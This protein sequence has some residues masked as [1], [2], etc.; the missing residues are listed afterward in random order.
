MLHEARAVLLQKKS[1]RLYQQFGNFIGAVVVVD[2]F[3]VVFVVIVAIT[4]SN[5]AIANITEKSL[6]IGISCNMAVTIFVL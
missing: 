5:L 1:W 3:V 4:Y 2:V 6:L